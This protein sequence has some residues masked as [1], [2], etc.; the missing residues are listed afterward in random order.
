V[1][2]GDG[3]VVTVTE[4]GWVGPPLMRVFARLFMDPAASLTQYLNDLGRHLGG[5]GPV[6][7]A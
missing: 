1:P 7:P 5:A 2:A 4:R 3:T 6:E